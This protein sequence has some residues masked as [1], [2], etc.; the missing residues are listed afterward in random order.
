MYRTPTTSRL[1]WWRWSMRR[2]HAGCRLL[3]LVQQP[4]SPGTG[5]DLAEGH[6]DCQGIRTELR[7]F[8]KPVAQPELAAKSSY[9]RLPCIGAVKNWALGPLEDTREMPY[10]L[11]FMQQS[12]STIGCWSSLELNLEWLHPRL[13]HH[14]TV[15]QK[16]NLAYLHDET[17]PWLFQRYMN[18]R[19]NHN[20]LHYNN[21]SMKMIKEKKLLMLQKDQQ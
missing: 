3:P 9:L 8:K 2:C 13:Q 5:A 21:L 19:K 17:T 10:G 1:C 11:R 15:K 4:S 6:H 12:M 16:R 20:L 18:D 7:P 14:T